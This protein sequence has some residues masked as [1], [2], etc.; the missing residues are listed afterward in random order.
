MPCQMWLET[1]AD[2]LWYDEG[3][4]L[5]AQS[6]KTVAFMKSRAEGSAQLSQDTGHGCFFFF[7]LKQKFTKFYLQ[8]SCM[9]DQGGK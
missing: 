2:I 6:G 9:I 8:G 3:S 7:L 4:T 1:A 5:F